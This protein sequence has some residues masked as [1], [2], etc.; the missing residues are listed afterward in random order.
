[1]EEKINAGSWNVISTG[2]ASTI[3]S[4]SSKPSNNYTYRIRAANN[5]GL[6]SAYN[7]TDGI[8]V[9]TTAPGAPG[10]AT[11]G[12]PDQDYDDDG[13]FMVTWPAAVD[14]G[15]G[16]KYYEL[17]EMSSLPSS[18]VVSSTIV[19][20][21]YAISG[22]ANGYTYT[23]QVRAQNNAG[24]WGPLSTVSDG[25]LIDKTAPNQP[26]TPSEGWPDEDWDGDGSFTINWTSAADGQSGID[27]Y[28][29]QETVNWTVWNTIG[30]NVSGTSFP[31][32]GRLD[33]RDYAYQVRARNMAGSW[34]GYS[35]YSDGV[36]VD[37]APPITPANVTEGEPSDLDRTNLTSFVLDWEDCYDTGSG[38]KGYQ[39]WQEIN[40]S[41]GWTLLASNLT[42]SNYSISG[43]ASGN[44]YSYRVRALDNMLH[45]SSY[46]Y[47]DGVAVDLQ[48]P[49]NLTL[50]IN[51]AAPYTNDTECILAINASD[52]QTGLQSM[53]FSENGV[54]WTAW[55]PFNTTKAYNL[56]SA[57][58]PVIVRLRVRDMANN[59]AYAH[60]GLIFDNVAP[61]SLS[62]VING[63]AASCTNRNLT[64]TLSATDA[65]SAVKEMRF[66]SDGL[67]WSAWEP[68]ATS[69]VYTVGLVSGTKTV[70][71][72]VRDLVNNTAPAVSSSILF[73]NPNAPYN[74]SILINGGSLYTNDRNVTLTLGASTNITT[75]LFMR[76]G[77]SGLNWTDWE[78]FDTTRDFELN[79][80]ANGEHRIY[81]QVK[82][83]IGNSPGGVHSSIMLDT[84]PPD[85]LNITI[86]SGEEY[87]GDLNVSLF[88]AAH[89]ALSGVWPISLMPSKMMSLQG[90]RWPMDLLGALGGQGAPHHVR[91]QEHPLL[92]GDGRRRQRRRASQRF[93]NNRPDRPGRRA[94]PEQRVQEHCKPRPE[95]GH[96]GHRQLVWHRENVLLVRRR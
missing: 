56:T 53:S 70:H 69:K 9:D 85:G 49:F 29:V 54:V 95:T 65:H 88:T 48:P 45:W 64:L 30:T 59:T 19:T 55:E 12:S 3:Y 94:Y 76:F 46:G 37:L 39:V 10:I 16:I 34:G 8:C 60:A 83:E 2:Y 58:G 92:Q 13:A 73:V 42:Q 24:L 32:T 44:S 52:N 20:T 90:Q 22:L 14:G 7:T 63:G 33:A 25:C 38:L 79:T 43:L 89:D 96:I 82:D 84:V 93:H 17:T 74:L 80:S 51:G 57:P 75:D 72:Q 81:Y 77:E 91:G 4:F 67:A 27:V 1:M 21:S 87:A 50:I 18:A 86:N 5:A 15:S 41:G 23:Y 40:G 28:E 26:G 31:V 36:T 35:W 68:Y 11:E 78:I 71:F 6:Y 47:S 61:H 62:V 66:S